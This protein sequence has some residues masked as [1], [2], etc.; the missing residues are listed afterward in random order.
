[1]SQSRRGDGGTQRENGRVKVAFWSK[2]KCVVFFRDLRVRRAL[3]LG[4][5]F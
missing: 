3:S 1:M 4:F 5:F 2:G